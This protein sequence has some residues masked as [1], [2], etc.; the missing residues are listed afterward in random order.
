MEL[1]RILKPFAIALAAVVVLGGVSQIQIGSNI[2]GV[3][4]TTGVIAVVPPGSTTPVWGT[5]AGF[6]ISSTGQVTVAAAAL[7]VLVQGEVPSGTLDGV[8][9]AFTTANIPASG[10]PVFIVRNGLIMSV[11]NGDYAL[12]GNKIAFGVGQVPQP[13]DSV[14]VTYYH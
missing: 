2:K 7:P 9:T 1:H 11:Q 10:W 13:G 12:T 4:T 6:S 14:N 8:N 3:N 5:P